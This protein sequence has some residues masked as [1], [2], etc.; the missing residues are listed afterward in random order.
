MFTPKI[1][2]VLAP[3]ILLSGAAQARPQM[4]Q[5]EQMR[6][7]E[8]EMRE[9]ERQMAAAARQIAELSSRHM[10]RVTELQRG[11]I[12]GSGRPMLGVNVGSGSDGGPVEGAEIVGVSPGGA[13]DGAGLRSGDI[14]IAV[15]GE[16]LSAGSGGEAAGKLIDYMA[17]VEEGATLDIEYLR[18]DNITSIQI[19]PRA[20]PLGGS[21]FA[22]PVFSMGTPPGMHAPSTMPHTVTLWNADGGWGDMEMVALTDRLGS[23]FGA[24]EGLLVVRAPQNE[25]LQLEDGDV[26]Q[27]IGGRVPN[28]VSHATRILG[29]YQAGE[30]LEIMI[31]RD[32]QKQTLNI[33]MPDQRTGSLR[34]FTMQPEFSV[35]E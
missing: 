27:S 12:I 22:G 4:E 21:A 34:N 16:S 30:T 2:L 13:A 20:V 26:I 1:F 8:L 28:S 5:Q 10:P 14:I 29:S 35:A 18:G 32:K 11:M 17:G 7:V 3:L 9:A 6:Q 33:E 31:M 15:N 24:D 23:Y 25:A 19:T